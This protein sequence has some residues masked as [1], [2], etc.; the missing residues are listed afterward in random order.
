[1]QAWKEKGSHFNYKSNKI[2]YVD[3]GV[4]DAIVFVHGFPTSSWDWNLLWN[5]LKKQY[6]LLAFDMIG[7]G[8]SDKPHPYDYTLHDQTDLL[9][10][11][12]KL[13]KLTNLHIL[14]HDYGDT[15]IQEFLA[16]INEKSTDTQ[17]F[18]VHSICLLNGGL[19]PGVH[20]PR[21]IQKLLMTKLGPLI[22]HFFTKKKLQKT[23][24]KIFGPDTQPTSSD[25]D[26]FWE[27]LRYNNGKQVFPS[28]I[29]YMRER[30]IHQKRWLK[31]LQNTKIPIRL[32][33]GASDPISG[34]HL[35]VHYEQVISN[36]DVI[37][38]EKIGHY[39][40]VE[41]SKQVLKHFLDFIK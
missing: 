39:P 3:E 35:G 15:V 30:E 13:H 37:Y 34:R 6:R 4:G 17:H 31:A 7:F 16:R 12:I 33:V 40:Q 19:F 27:I 8:F 1:M 28:L 14:A 22:S 25:M 24:N 41:A 20:K 23:F 36:H 29:Q 9:I 21:L 26:G 18:K 10:S 5:D 11:F 32:I 2:F 38:L